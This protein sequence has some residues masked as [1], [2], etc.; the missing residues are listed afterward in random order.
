MPPSLGEGTRAQL[1]D[2]LGPRLLS[3]YQ[4]APAPMAT[5]QPLG[6]LERVSSSHFPLL[7]TN[8]EDTKFLF[9]ASLEIY[10]NG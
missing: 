6:H 3:S 5:L 10:E 4:D 1:S 9:P 8:F 2:D 7:A